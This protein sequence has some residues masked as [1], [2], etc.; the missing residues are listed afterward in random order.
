MVRHETW[1]E[2]RRC[3]RKFGEVRR[4]IIV[5]PL[6][7]FAFVVPRSLLG[8]GDQLR[9]AGRADEYFARLA[10]GFTSWKLGHLFVFVAFILDVEY[11]RLVQLR[12]TGRVSAAT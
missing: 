10:H 5:V 1:H 4:N 11:S 6:L 7:F 3:V 12:D 9:R 8:R 2:L